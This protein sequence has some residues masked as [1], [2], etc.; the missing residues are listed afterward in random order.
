MPGGVLIASRGN[1]FNTASGEYEGG[2]TEMYLPLAEMGTRD[3]SC[4]VKA[5]GA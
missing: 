4:G 1:G 5:A 3:I 2:T